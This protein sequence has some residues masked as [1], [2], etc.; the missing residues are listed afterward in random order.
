MAATPQIR[1]LMERW[2]MLKARR[3][4]HE[5]V[6]QELLDL[7]APFR[8]DVTTKKSMGSKRLGAIFDSTASRAADKF[9]NFLMGAIFPNTGD[10]L[11]LRPPREIAGDER[12]SQLLDLTRLRV[13]EALSESNFYVEAAQALRD[14]S[15]LANMTVSVEEL[16]PTVNGTA[17]FRGLRFEAIPVF[18][19]WWQLGRGR[20]NYIVRRVTMP[21]LDAVREFSSYPGKNILDIARR[22]PMEDVEILHFVY[23]NEEG[24]PG[25]L[26]P[27]A[28]KPWTSIWVAN[29]GGDNEAIIPTGKDEAIGGF[30]FLP[31]ITARWLTVQGEEYGRGPGH[32][33]RPDAKGVNKLKELVLIAAGRDINPVL[34]TEDDSVTQLDAG[35]S[36]VAVYR[37]GARPP[38]YLRSGSDYRVADEIGRQDREQINQAFFIDVFGEPESQPRSAEESLQRRERALA[39]LAAPARVVERAFLAPVI[40]ATLQLM[41]RADA[42][43]ELEEYANLSGSDRVES[44]FESPFFTATKSQAAQKTR[45]F[46]A[47]AIER[48]GATGDPSWLDRLDPDEITRLDAELADVDARIFR[49]EE[50]IEAVR[51]ARAERQA[52]EE[53]QRALQTVGRAGKGLSALQEGGAL[54]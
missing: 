44:T 52:A 4:G 54:G 3:L 35:P 14:L 47:Q 5:T 18:D 41:Q 49:S 22:Q 27:A 34:L 29:A 53:A 33:A 10:W 13:L 11:K 25:D 50:E 1:A 9:A 23:E 32:F 20:V 42:L 6:W 46:V 40:S 43:P 31:Y 24:I 37:P 17:A 19:Y 16:P 30:D 7:M 15:I 39:Q 48:A 51:N 12:L 45:V 38:E 26:V 2:E 28:N 21:A 8:G 36:G